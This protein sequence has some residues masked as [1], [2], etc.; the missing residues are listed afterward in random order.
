MVSTTSYSSYRGTRSFLYS[1]SHLNLCFQTTTVSKNHQGQNFMV[2][3]EEDSPQYSG[4]APAITPSVSIRSK[5]NKRQRTTSAGKNDGMTSQRLSESPHP[6]GGIP[7]SRSPFSN[8][9]GQGGNDFDLM[10]P[11]GFRGCAGPR[12]VQKLREGKR[13]C[14]TCFNVNTFLL[15]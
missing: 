1:F 9:G 7:M 2:Q 14:T 15:F 3:V 10:A 4:V 11:L 5:R 13:V 8:D 6:L 12:E